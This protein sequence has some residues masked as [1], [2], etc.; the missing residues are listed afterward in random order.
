M[1]RQAH[2]YLA[3]AVSGTALVAAAVVVFVM[4]VSFQALKDWPLTDLI[5]GD[6]GASVSNGHAVQGGDCPGGVGCGCRWCSGRR[7]D[8]RQRRPWRWRPRDGGRQCDRP[9]RG[10]LT[11]RQRADRDRPGAGSDP[12]SEQRLSRLRHAA[13][14]VEHG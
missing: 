10:A 6:D 8:K 5:G 4:L 13:G 14:F 2:N 3:G 11:L 9:R 7:G 12:G 1:V